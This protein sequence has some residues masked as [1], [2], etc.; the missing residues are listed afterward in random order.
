M[1]SR[2]FALFAAFALLSLFAALALKSLAD[3]SSWGYSGDTGPEYWGELSPEY[4]LCADG[5][6]Q[7]PIDIREAS[8]LDLVDIE[9]Q[10]G[11]SANNIFNNGH[12]IQGSGEFQGCMN[13]MGKALYLGYC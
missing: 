13:C 5:A 1:K 7:S 3:E 4:A 2:A 9:F 10:Y 8:E 6:A 12:T 11:E